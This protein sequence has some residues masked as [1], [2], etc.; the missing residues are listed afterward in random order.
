[1][2]KSLNNLA[3]RGVLCL[4]WYVVQV[5]GKTLHVIYRLKRMHQT[6]TPEQLARALLIYNEHATDYR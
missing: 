4:A 2:C 5:D 6:V 1:M 3:I